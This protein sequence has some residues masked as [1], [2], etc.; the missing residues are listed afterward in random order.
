MKPSAARR[1]ALFSALAPALLIGSAAVALLA[2]LRPHAYGLRHELVIAIGLFALW[3]YGWLVV[4]YVRAAIYSRS[5]YPWLRRQAEHIAAQ[6]PLPQRVFVVVASYL[7]DPWVSAEAFQAL[8]ANV[9]SLPCRVTVVAA[10][11]SD[12]DEAVIAGV[13]ARHSARH[14]VELVFQ[15]QQ[16]G[17]RIALGHALRAVARR[18]QDDPNSVTVLMDGDSKLEPDAILRSL[19]FF[20]AYSD[21]G[22]VTTN[23][24][25]I[26]LAGGG[27]LRDWFGLKFA[28]RHMLFQS[29]SLSHRVLTL[30]GRFS[31]FRTAILVRE[32]FIRSIEHDTLT[33]WMHG[34]FRFLMGDDKSTWFYL[35]RN[36]WK[37]LYLPDVTC[38]CLESRDPG[39]VETTIS[40][41]YRWSGNTLRNNPRALAL[42]PRRTGWFIWWVIL[43]QRLSM[44]TSIVG[45]AGAMTLAAVKSF[46]FL[47]MYLAWAVLVRTLQTVMLAIYGHPVSLRTVPLMLYTQWVGALV[48]IHAWNHL[49]DQK[50]S[51]G[52][53]R[54]VGESERSALQRMLP[55]M[56]MGLSYCAF[57]VLVLLA[58]SAL[59]FPDVRLFAAEAGPAGLDVA[60]YGV[61]ADDGIDDAAPLQALLDKEGGRGSV[62]LRLPA[63][64]LD[65]HTPLVIRHGDVSISGA[66]AERTRIVS[67][68]RTPAQA[69]IT[70]QGRRGSALGHLAESLKGDATT[71]RVEADMSS[72]EPG[73]LLWIRQPNDAVLFDRLG[74]VQWRREQPF[75]RQALLP[76]ASVDGSQVRVMHPAGI[77]FDADMAEAV[78]VQPVRDVRLSDFAIEQL[79]AGRD[80]AQVAYR[81]ENLAPEVAVDGIRLEWTEGVR[82]ERVAIHAAGRHPVSIEHSHGFQLRD[83]VIDGAWNKGEG[84]NGYLRIARSFRGT[85]ENCEVRNIRHIALQW[86]SA[87]NKLRNLRS[88]VDINFHGGYSHHNVAEGI[89]WALPAQHPWKSVTTTP[90]NAAWAP[91]DGPGNRVTASR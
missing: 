52:R 28:L 24:R 16:H 14:K 72:L 5:H 88:E 17:K 60:A 86:S 79:V 56:K 53:M 76:V 87:H 80:I 82:I 48:R 4:N 30:T 15:R 37:M 9:A 7:E 81:Y 25:A 34:Q 19:P 61:R 13:V 26:M 27:W 33:H 63:G 46:V 39:F 2:W 67:H 8:M 47:P 29:H 91:P 40:L 45:L 71:V 51:K 1:H 83:C 41:P 20:A 62:I 10:V 35:L 38:W 66:G 75:L 58:H 43:D 11:G 74:S 6:A 49:S 84:G 32:D 68:L 69:V 89:T 18:S 90:R 73:D 22:A 77:T 59:R 64:R 70:V 55:K 44:W 36:G 57:A 78:R 85:V 21:L 54:Q 50:W 12:A 65:F 3:R 23:E 31:V 42:G